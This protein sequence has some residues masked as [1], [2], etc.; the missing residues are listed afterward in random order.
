M[1]TASDFMY[2]FRTLFYEVTHKRDSFSSV[3]I[4]LSCPII[5]TS[6]PKHFP[7]LTRSSD[8]ICHYL[9][10]TLQFTAFAVIPYT[11]LQRFSTYLELANQKFM[12]MENV[13]MEYCSFKFLYKEVLDSLWRFILQ[14]NCWNVYIN[15][16][17]FVD[18]DI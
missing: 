10:A 16:H 1:F 9:P 11:S 18:M 4:Y 17:F 15:V 6:D 13:V 14:R 3:V 8:S 7:L 2:P 12:A 5:I